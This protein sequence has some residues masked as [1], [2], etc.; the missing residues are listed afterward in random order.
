MGVVN[1][2]CVAYLS[3]H[4][5]DESSF[6]CDARSSLLFFKCVRGGALFY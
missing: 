4:Y 6:L 2:N 1:I 5:S 3:C